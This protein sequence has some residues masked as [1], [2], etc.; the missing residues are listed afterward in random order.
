MDDHLRMTFIRSNHK[1]K[2]EESERS[3][4]ACGPAQACAVRLERY[5]R[6]PALVRLCRC[7]RRLSCPAHPLRD[8]QALEL[9]NRA[10]F[11][12]CE[13][14]NNWPECALNDTAI[15]IPAEYQTMNPDELEER[16]NQ[17][18]PMQPPKI[19]FH[20][21]CRYP[22]TWSLDLNS[23]NSSMH[24]YNC[25]ELPSCE[26]GDFC[27]NVRD[28][29]MSLYQSCLC[30]QKHICVHSGG[31]D[32]VNISEILYTGKGKRAY[33]QRYDDGNDSYEDY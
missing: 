20:C 5:W 17:N 14:V 1:P 28:D 2:Q 7:A 19:T 29:L 23:N 22:Y 12:F 30:P 8:E 13:P 6:P 11:K 3:L 33:C 10:H 21:H 15:S 4:P 27:G 18:K 24:Q 25:I 26:S 32:Y 9:N 31:I 16:H